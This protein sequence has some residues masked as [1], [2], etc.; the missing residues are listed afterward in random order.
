MKY[1]KRLVCTL[2]GLAMAL[3]LAACGT[4]AAQGSP[5]PSAT[6]TATAPTGTLTG[7]EESSHYLYAPI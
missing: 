3:S 7:G 4:P 2:L 1:A 5:S 6:P